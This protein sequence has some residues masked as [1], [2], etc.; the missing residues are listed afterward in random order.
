MA[1]LP[2]DPADLRERAS[3][4]VTS[5]VTGYSYRIRRINQIDFNRHKISTILPEKQGAWDELGAEDQRVF[6]SR[7]LD[8]TQYT[9]E[10]GANIFFGEESATPPGAIHVDWI[11]GDEGFLSDEILKFSGLD[12]E[13]QKA[14]EDLLKNA[15]GSGSPTPLEELTDASPATF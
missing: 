14:I 8:S 12:T 5:P 4:I 10:R 7:V 9:L 1:T 2:T 6:M 15:N 11:A 13:S 3:K